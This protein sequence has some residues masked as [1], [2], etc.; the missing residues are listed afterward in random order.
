MP[1]TR[2]PRL[3]HL[4]ALLG[5]TLTVF[6]SCAT[7][8]ASSGGIP[9]DRGNGHYT[10]GPDYRIDPDLADRG[11]P[12]GRQ[13][14]FAMPL[15]QSRIFRGDDP[16]LEPAKKAVRVQRKIFVYIPASYRDGRPAPYLVIHDGPAQLGPVRNALDNLAGSADPART[17]PPFVAVAV[18]NGGNDGKN[19]QRGFS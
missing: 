14:E 7:R 18:E 5:F 17:L 19:S 10:V 3:R 12:K 1:P 13:F 2:P 11:R 15:A 4:A 8:T 16:T 9:R 6:A